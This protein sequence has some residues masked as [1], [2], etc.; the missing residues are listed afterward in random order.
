MTF[1]EKHEYWKVE[2]LS[3]IT[4]NAMQI[5]KNF[6]VVQTLRT[7]GFTSIISVINDW[8]SVQNSSI[9]MTIL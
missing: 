5:E 2:V 6:F 7:I 1:K 3:L 4:A 8:V 9:P